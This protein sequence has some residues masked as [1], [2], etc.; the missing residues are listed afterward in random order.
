MKKVSIILLAFLL[1]VTL[2]AAVGCDKTPDVPSAT[3]T[4]TAPETEPLNPWA[5]LPAADA[6]DQLMEGVSGAE[7]GESTETMDNGRIDMD[8]SMGIQVSA[9]GVQNTTTL[10]I[11]LTVVIDGQNLMLDANLMGTAAAMTYKDGVLYYVTPE[12]Q[13]RYKCALTPEEFEEVSSLLFGLEEGEDDGI[14]M[15][16]LPGIADRKP[17]SLFASVSSQ[18]DETNGDLIIT[19]KGINSAL[20]TDLAPLLQPILESLGLVG[21]GE[22]DE[23]GEL[24]TDPAA[25]LAEV[26]DLLRELNEDTLQ[27]TFIFDKAGNLL[28]TKVDLTLAMEEGGDSVILNIKGSFS[29]KEGGQSVT[30]PADAASYTEEHW[31]VVFGMETA[32]MLG[33]VPDADGCITLSSNEAVR[34]RQ[35]LYIYNHSE[36]MVGYLYNLGGYIVDSYIVDEETATRPSDVGAMEGM[37]SLCDPAFEEEDYTTVISFQIPL[38]AKGEGYPAEGDFLKVSYAK[39]EVVVDSAFGSYMYLCVTDYLA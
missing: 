9:E 16:E 11:K 13:L 25:T 33:L 32:E 15:P 27:L 38:S 17:S 34:E 22:W 28:T 21:G 4:E 39:L 26:V 19:A 3:D 23:N 35:I 24:I 18:L 31:R 37:L 2:A 30:L 12:E 14:A 29:V 20:A 5:D 7:S 1:A 6:L 36:E 8:L 10:P